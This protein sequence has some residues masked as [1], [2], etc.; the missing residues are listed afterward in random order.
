M[1]TP[2]NKSLYLQA[3][4]DTSDTVVVLH[5]HTNIPFIEGDSLTFKVYLNNRGNKSLLKTYELHI[6][7]SSKELNK[8]KL[9]IDILLEGYVESKYTSL[10]YTLDRVSNSDSIT[11]TE[12]DEF[13]FLRTYGSLKLEC[14][15]IKLNNN[16]PIDTLTPFIPVKSNVSCGVPCDI[17]CYYVVLMD[18]DSYVEI[19]FGEEKDSG[20]NGGG[21]NGGG[22]G[23]NGNGEGEGGE[24]GGEEPDKKYT[25]KDI[26]PKGTTIHLKTMGERV[27]GYYE[28]RG[29][30]IYGNVY[31]I[32]MMNPSHIKDV[33]YIGFDPEVLPTDAVFEGM[34]YYEQASGS[35]NP[36]IVE[37]PYYTFLTWGF[38]LPSDIEVIEEA[39]ETE[40]EEPEDPEEGI[41][42]IVPFENRP[43]KLIKNHWNE[44]T[45]SGH[46]HSRIIVHEGS[47]T[48]VLTF[49]SRNTGQIWDYFDQFT[50]ESNIGD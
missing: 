35:T 15:D 45:S 48:L 27:Q 18:G 47:P 7:S 24:N 16:F 23:G 41:V 5:Y 40:S 1:T 49:K 11:P 46:W 43:F 13:H 39:L 33:E 22:E 25:L 6:D 29:N 26:F 3:V 14:T 21:N 31:G 42:E 30:Q 36:P 37:S 8:N 38:K 2:I 19:S 17:D 28:F 9:S 12:L 10:S 32:S 50:I 44:L 34:S 20:E 4:K